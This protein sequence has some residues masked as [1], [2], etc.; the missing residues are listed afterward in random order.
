MVPMHLGLIDRPFVPHNLIS[1]QHS[2]VPLLKFQLGPRPKIL[3]SSASKEPTYTIL[4]SQRVVADKSLAGSPAGPLRREI[5]VYRA[6]YI[7]L[8]ISLYLKS[9]K[10]RASLQVSPKRSPYGNRRPCQS[11]T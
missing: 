4:F 8:D 5:P 3:M 11:L 6:F 2:P 1:A 7:S 10:K 9:P